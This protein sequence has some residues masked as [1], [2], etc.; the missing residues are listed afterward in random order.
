M[1]GAR[2]SPRSG[3]GRRLHRRDSGGGP[4]PAR[5]WSSTP[6]TGAKRAALKTG[7]AWALEHGYDAVLTLDADGQHDPAEI[8][9]FLAALEAG[10][11][12]PHHRAKGVSP[13]APA[14]LV[15]HPLGTFLLSLALGRYIPDNQS[16][17]RLITRRR[18][19]PFI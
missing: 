16:G 6:G 14:A 18:W 3:R 12:G 7:F 19:R 9:K 2:F 4:R 1:E 13:H 5:R 10:A 15:V 17:Y 11:G 8:P